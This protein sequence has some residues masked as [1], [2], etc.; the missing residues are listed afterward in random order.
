[1]VP[2]FSAKP[3]YFTSYPVESPK[4]TLIP[5][6][7]SGGALASVVTYLCMSLYL[8]LCIVWNPKYRQAWPGN[9]I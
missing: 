9:F 4:V 8:L 6:F 2:S 3:F 5:L 1:M 7:R